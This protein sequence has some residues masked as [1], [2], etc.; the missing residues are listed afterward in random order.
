[1]SSFKDELR[2][3][4]QLLILFCGS[5][6]AAAQPAWKFD[7]SELPPGM[8]RE[9]VERILK[10]Q[11]QQDLK[12]IEREL[13]KQRARADRVAR[14]SRKYDERIAKAIAR[15]PELQALSDKVR[16]GLQAATPEG[17]TPEQEAQRLSA[18]SADAKRLRELAMTSA[19][20]NRKEMDAEIRQALNGA[21]ASREAGDSTD[22]AEAYDVDGDGYA[23][24]L[25]EQ[26]ERGQDDS[27]TTRG[28]QTI[29]VTRNFRLAYERK[30]VAGRAMANRY[31]GEFDALTDLRYVGS[32][33][34]YAGVGHYIYVPRGTDKVRIRASVPGLIY[35]SNFVVS[36]GGGAQSKTWT[37]FRAIDANLRTRCVDTR[38]HADLWAVVLGSFSNRTS[39][40]FVSMSCEFAPPP[41]PLYA[42][43][44]SYA[45]GNAWGNA[46]SKGFLGP[47]YPYEVK[48]E[49]ELID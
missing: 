36:V 30:N 43:V 5:A 35:F 26:E 45:Y 49:F 38:V 23:L 19:G 34:N 15:D 44:I 7:P 20:I 28:T 25:E 24:Q 6:M 27:V 40:H 31:S 37:Q 11:D 39:R 16:A 18:I 14:A 13:N 8:A 41:G 21:V 48:F 1:M 17:Y 47:L 3:I 22:S 46:S 10:A 2:S 9:D 32:G 42:R 4:A 29:S 12:E 33:T